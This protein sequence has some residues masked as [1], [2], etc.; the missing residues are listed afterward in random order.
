VRKRP[1]Y[2]PTHGSAAVGNALHRSVF[3]FPDGYKF[4][5]QGKLW[6]PGAGNVRYTRFV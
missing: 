6:T 3:L 1:F 5:F 2:Q 4:S